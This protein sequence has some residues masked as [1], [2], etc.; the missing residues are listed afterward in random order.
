LTKEAGEVSRN[1]SSGPLNRGVYIVLAEQGD[2]V[3]VRQY[4]VEGWVP[5]SDLVTLDDALAHFG[6]RI[7]TNPSDDQA[8][9]MRAPAH[10]WDGRLDNA[11]QDI[12]EAIRLNPSPAW[13]NNRGLTYH[14]MKDQDRAIAD[15]TEAIRLDPNNFFAYYNRG[16]AYRTKGDFTQA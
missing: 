4:G 16:N 3:R 2:S 6:E 13:Y 11:I 10:G 5:K 12:N 14:N 15:Y 9:A 1:E 7:R 8:W